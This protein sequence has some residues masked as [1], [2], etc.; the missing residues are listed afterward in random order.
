MTDKIIPLTNDFVQKLFNRA[1]CLT[2]HWIG[3]N[4]ALEHRHRLWKAY[5]YKPCYFISEKGKFAPSGAT[6]HF[7]SDGT[8][9]YAHYVSKEYLKRFEKIISDH[10]YKVTQRLGSFDIK[11]G[12]TLDDIIKIDKYAATVYDASKDIKLI[13]LP[14]P[15]E[16][17]DL[18]FANG[19]T[20]LTVSKDEVINPE[21]RDYMALFDNGMYFVA[22]E[23]TRIDTIY[24]HNKIRYFKQNH[25]QYVYFDAIVV[26]YNHIQAIYTKA[27]D[28]AWF[29]TKEN[30]L[31][32]YN[33]AHPHIIISP[34]EKN[35]ICALIKNNKC[36]S[37]VPCANNFLSPDYEKYALFDDGRL[38]V[39]EDSKFAKNIEI[40]LQ[41]LYPD[42]PIQMFRVPEYYIPIMYEEALKHQKSAKNIY[43]EMLKQKA[44][45]LKKMLNIP[46]HEALELSAKITGWNNWKEVTLIDECRARHAINAE[47]TKKEWATKQNYDALENEYQKYVRKCNHTPKSMLTLM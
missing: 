29:E 43:I 27:K 31:R 44:R 39:Y 1:D 22:E 11:T 47:R 3:N 20:C 10:G 15:K 25:P 41:A 16:F 30:A 14:S 45:K 46:H 24:E 38:F 8:L 18:I 34:E 2:F 37:I 23:Y 5:N 9:I 13:P 28:F 35:K 19:N 6:V 26:P 7:F 42:L 40:K 36:L 32:K 33:E 12:Y 4:S 21:C 17:A